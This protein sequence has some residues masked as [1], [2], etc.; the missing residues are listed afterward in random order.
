MCFYQ[1]RDVGLDTID[2]NETGKHESEARTLTPDTETRISSKT[3]VLKMGYN[4]IM[5]MHIQ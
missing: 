1:S 5:A 2:V 3:P 4:T